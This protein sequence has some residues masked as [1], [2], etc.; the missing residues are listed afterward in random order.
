[1]FER[2]DCFTINEQ[3]K[4]VDYVFHTA[5]PFFESTKMRDCEDSI[6]KYVEAS[7]NLIEQIIQSKIKKIVFTGSATSVIG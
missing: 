4:D 2:K 1:M 5:S 3:L 6:K 7:Q